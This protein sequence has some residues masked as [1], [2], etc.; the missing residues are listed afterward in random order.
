MPG[1]YAAGGVVKGLDQVVIAMGH[2]A[3]AATDVHN[4]LRKAGA[5]RVGAA[6][7]ENFRAG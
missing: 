3:V 1:L 2:A 6:K 7:A 4:S 5:A